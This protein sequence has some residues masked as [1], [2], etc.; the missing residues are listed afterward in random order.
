MVS[1][2]LLA[3]FGEQLGKVL[4]QLRPTGGDFA[5]STIQG[6]NLK[7]RVQ[8]IRQVLKGTTWKELPN[9][10]IYQHE[11]TYDDLLEEIT[12][13]KANNPSL[14]AIIPTYG[15]PMNEGKD[16][17]TFVDNNRDL[18]VVVADAMPH[19]V[20]LM[21]RG[22]AD[23]LVGQLPYQSG[24]VC[25]DTLLQLQEVGNPERDPDKELI[26]GTNLSLLLRVPLM[27]PEVR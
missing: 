27:L 7:L 2:F 11:K 8:G 6:E 4:L 1:L 26:F 17:T 24:E 5:L 21:E 12:E 18:T 15:G 14:K 20:Q 9:S 22:Y 19:Q 3:A 25:I 13:L 23:G 10:M 16:W